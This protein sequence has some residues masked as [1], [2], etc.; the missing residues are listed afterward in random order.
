MSIAQHHDPQPSREL[1]EG[2]VLIADRDAEVY[3]NR[4]RH[5][6]QVTLLRGTRV[7]HERT[8][9]AAEGIP[10]IE[11]ADVYLVVLDGPLAG[12]HVVALADLNRTADVPRLLKTL[13]FVLAA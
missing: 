7:W 5:D 13:G 3:L 10:D 1:P 6:E 9:R 2:A 8:D 11:H 12:R 4:E